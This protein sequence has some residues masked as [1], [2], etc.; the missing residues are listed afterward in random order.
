MRI[1]LRHHS[2]ALNAIKLQSAPSNIISIF[3]FRLV[4]CLAKKLQS[5][6]KLTSLDNRR[7]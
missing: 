3:D 1:V 5:Q 6:A 2:Q 4:F 7:F